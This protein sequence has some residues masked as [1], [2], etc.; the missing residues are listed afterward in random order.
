ML[1]VQQTMNSFLNL[2]RGKEE[3]GPF[4]RFKSWEYCHLKFVEGHQKRINNQLNEDDIDI[5]ALHLSFYLAS[6]GMYRGSSFILQRDYKTH[7]RIVRIVLQEKYD[8]LWDFNPIDKNENELNR[9]AELADEA[10]QEIDRDGYGPI[11]ERNMV[12]DDNEEDEISN[13]HISY[14][15]I[16]KIL[17][18]TF[19]ITPAF[20]RFF[21]DGFKKYNNANHTKGSNYCKERLVK[22]F[23][24]VQQH[25]EEL[26]VA[27][28]V[29]SF[30]Y[31]MMK[32]VDMYFW[33]V[34]YEF[35]FIK[36][37]EELQKYLEEE[38]ITNIL[39]NKKL[40]VYNKLKLQIS[41]FMPEISNINDSHINTI[42]R[43]IAL[44]NQRIH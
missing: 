24:F 13:E 3:G 38:N 22:L 14:T 33:E 27:D 1:T 37:L 32:K 10:Y 26:N 2:L 20:D 25:H 17:M 29:T 18:G 42:A 41:S 44:I 23:S 40:R 43:I 21:I 4:S 36:P 5:L 34:G 28:T 16:T 9:I 31:P 35:G 19:A 39:D 15:L 8:E 11:P 12:D 6:W 7:K 30:P